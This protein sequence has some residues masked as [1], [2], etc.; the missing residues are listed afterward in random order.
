M[1]ETI[2]VRNP[3]T[4]ERDY[5][6]TAASAAEVKTAAARLRRGQAAWQE[7]GLAGRITALTALAE[8]VEDRIG[9]LY[10]ALKTDEGR[11]RIARYEIGSF[12]GLVRRCAED[13]RT[14]LAEPAPRP[15]A[16]PHVT[17]SG[18]WVPYGLIGNIS[19][20]NFP[21]IL[22]MI[23][24]IPALMAGNA[25][26]VKP[27]EVTPR[28][29]EPMREAIAEVPDVASVL[30]FVMGP[31][32]TG[33]ALIDVVDLIVFTGSVRTGRIVAEAA[34]RAFIPAFLELGGK[35]PAIVTRSANLDAATAGILR[36]SIAATGQACQ[37]LERIYVD[38]T[39]HDAFV[40]KLVTR[41]KEV[42]LNLDDPEEG[43]LGPL[44][45]ERQADIIM[46][47]LR[48][49]RE[50]GARVLTGGTLIER[51]G[52]W[53]APTIVTHVSHD[54]TLMREETFGPVLPVM[55]VDSVEEAVALAND[56]A[57]G[58]S[59]SVYAGTSREAM[60]IARRLN[61]GTV[62]LNDASLTAFVHDIECDS[63]GVSG[64]GG[65]RFGPE[66]IRRFVRRKAILDN[67]LGP[68]DIFGKPVPLS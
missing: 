16:L 9:P 15:T 25:V 59:A 41:A 24:T 62:S 46:D 22:S 31:G 65:T 58:L 52:L 45:F 67:T 8:A 40:E 27:S 21:F 55:A 49:A 2:A 20:W 32:T 30:D 35:D 23:D 37:S 47:H 7:R 56:S 4:G 10:E 66:G 68:M 33:A 3:F 64:L 60:A 61:A 17:G 12:A 42:T 38:R 57:Y 29:V 1:P 26:L 28:W 14:M 51:G 34:A 19:P 63:F 18:Q 5:S 48:D 54:M 50:R 53:M 44:I 13:A 11:G 36:A 39:V 43:Y 6:F